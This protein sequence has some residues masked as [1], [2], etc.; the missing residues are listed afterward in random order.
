MAISKDV[1]ALQSSSNMGVLTQEQNPADGISKLRNAVNSLRSVVIQIMDHH[2][3]N[4]EI[5]FEL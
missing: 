1:I 3:S 5:F 4:R 2:T